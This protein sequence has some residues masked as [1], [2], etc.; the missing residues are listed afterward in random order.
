MTND[1]VG[2]IPA[3]PYGKKALAHLDFSRLGLLGFGQHDRDHAVFHFGADFT[4]ID[5]I[6]NFEAP[7]V[8]ADVVFGVPA[9]SLRIS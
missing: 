4:S 9:S 2:T 3:F 8:V 7:C 1:R 6:G 5:F